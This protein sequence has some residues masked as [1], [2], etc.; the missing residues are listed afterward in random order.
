LPPNANERIVKKDYIKESGEDAQ[1]KETMRLIQ[2]GFPQR[3]LNYK[4]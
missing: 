1:A 3:M 2:L 4:D